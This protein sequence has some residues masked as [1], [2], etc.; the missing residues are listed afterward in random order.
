MIAATGV[1]GFREESPETAVE[2]RQ[3]SSHHKTQRAGRPDSCARSTIPAPGV[4]F[5]SFFDDE[6]VA[7]ADTGSAVETACPFPEWEAWDAGVAD[8]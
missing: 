8:Q 5:F 4:S 3:K 6:F 2:P 7:T 1:P